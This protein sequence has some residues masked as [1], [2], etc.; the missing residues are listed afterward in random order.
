MRY[1]MVDE[2]FFSKD[3]KSLIR[4][5]RRDPRTETC[6]PCIVELVDDSSIELHG[7]VLDVTPR[8]MS[9]RMMEAIPLSTQVAVQLMRDDKYQKKLSTPHKGEIRRIE[10]TP[11]GFFDHGVLLHKEEIKKA[12]ERPI[13]IPRAKPARPAKPSRMKTIDYTVD[14]SNRKRGR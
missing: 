12:S 13:H 8:G 10:G 5:S 6:R 9:V 4:G 3:E 7:V 14:S 11:D 2:M 1:F